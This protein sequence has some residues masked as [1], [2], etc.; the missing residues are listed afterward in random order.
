MDNSLPSSV[1]AALQDFLGIQSPP[2]CFPAPP[3]DHS[4][5]SLAPICPWLVVVP[6]KIK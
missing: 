4:C 6:S 5:S 2:L 3:L 1:G